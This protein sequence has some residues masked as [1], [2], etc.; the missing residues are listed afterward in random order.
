MDGCPIGLGR[1]MI[2]EMI[3]YTNGSLN[4]TVH[5][6]MMDENGYADGFNL[7]I[8]DGEYFA[9]GSGT[10]YEIAL[11]ENFFGAIQKEP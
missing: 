7:A 8:L 2:N 9:D 10:K 6:T 4:A 1:E 5:V 3:H 11:H